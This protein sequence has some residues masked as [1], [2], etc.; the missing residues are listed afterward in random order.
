M[1]RLYHT[2]GFGAN[3]D[4]AKCTSNNSY[5]NMFSSCTSLHTLR[6][7]N[8]DRNTVKKII[9]S[10]NFPTNAID[11]VTRTIYCQGASAFALTAPENW[12]FSI[13]S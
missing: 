2:I 7:D 4:L 1:E 11:G 9:E 3:F 13:V 5:Y 12:T 6:L 8:C 10:S